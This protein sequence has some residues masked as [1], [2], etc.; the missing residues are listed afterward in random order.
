MNKGTQFK[1]SERGVDIDELKPVTFAEGP[2]AHDQPI[3]GGMW[4]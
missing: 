3:F 4:A 1:A 2:T